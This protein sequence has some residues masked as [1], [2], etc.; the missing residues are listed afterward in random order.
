MKSPLVTLLLTLAAASANASSIADVLA[1]DAAI[2]QAQE[3]RK[4][5]VKGLSKTERAQLRV[6][7]AEIALAKAQAAAGKKAVRA[8]KVVRE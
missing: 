7:Q 2:A 5:A 1:A 6:I 8:A 3:A 4:A